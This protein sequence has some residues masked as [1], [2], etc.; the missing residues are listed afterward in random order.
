L[1]VPKTKVLSQ[2]A[3]TRYKIQS[4]QS[5]PSNELLEAYALLEALYMRP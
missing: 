4:L 5:S 2:N 3:F 1:Q